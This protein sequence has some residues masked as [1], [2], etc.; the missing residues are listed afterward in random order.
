[1]IAATLVGGLLVYYLFGRLVIITEILFG[2]WHTW[3]GFFGL[4]SGLVA[5]AIFN[6]PPLRSALAG[7]AGGLALL[8][9]I[10]ALVPNPA[11][12]LQNSKGWD[13]LR[14]YSLKCSVP[15]K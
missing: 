7:Y 13:V 12:C 5:A 3:L 9:M 6:G 8:I 1:M 10:N 15:S 4:L 11:P 2:V 14:A